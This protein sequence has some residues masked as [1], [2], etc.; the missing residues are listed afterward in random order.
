MKGSG[1]VQ[2][3]LAPRYCWNVREVIGMTA[4]RSLTAIQWPSE[5]TSGV[6]GK[7]LPSPRERRPWRCFASSNI[8]LFSELSEKGKKQ[9]PTRFQPVPGVE[10][11]TI[12]EYM[13]SDDFLKCSVYLREALGIPASLAERIAIKLAFLGFSADGQV[14]VRQYPAPLLVEESIKLMVESLTKIPGIDLRRVAQNSP[15]IFIQSPEARYRMQD[16]YDWL[17]T[18][19]HL[20]EN[21]MGKILNANAYILTQPRERN[22]EPTVI[23]LK[24][25]NLDET[26]LR[27]V[28]LRYPRILSLRVKRL[29]QTLEKLDELGFD[30]TQVET[31]VSRFP[32]VCE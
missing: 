25:L 3:L 8:P 6:Q 16:N 22:S 24:S 15:F 17:K 20:Q 2:L 9:S 23:F 5:V 1:R 11:T 19:F 29:K 18:S 4:Y 26:Q 32:A 10:D 12:G 21:E 14:Y 28:V 31:I 7:L 13:Q 30:K 27:T